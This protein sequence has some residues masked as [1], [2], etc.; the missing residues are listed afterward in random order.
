MPCVLRKILG[1]LLLATPLS[2][3]TGCSCHQVE[4]CCHSCCD[5][6]Y[7]AIEAIAWLALIIVDCAD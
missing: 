3:G 1:S 2:L 7:E 5:C 4:H 6:C